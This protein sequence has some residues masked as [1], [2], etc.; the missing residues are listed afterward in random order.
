MLIKTSETPKL[1]F[2]FYIL[3]Y[4]FTPARF[5]CQ[6]TMVRKNTLIERNERCKNKFE[7]SWPFRQA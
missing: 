1:P 2:P 6:Q 7:F 3:G 4:F 5:D